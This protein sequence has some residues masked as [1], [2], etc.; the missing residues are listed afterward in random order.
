MRGFV[1]ET[2][3]WRA[4]LHG[5]GALSVLAGA[6]LAQQPAVADSNQGSEVVAGDVAPVGRWYTF[7]GSASRCGVSASRS[8]LGGQLAPAWEFGTDGLIEEEPLVW[9]EHVVI[10]TVPRSKAGEPAKERVLHALR[11]QDGKS[12]FPARKVASDV[13]LG[14]SMWG[15][16][17]AYREGRNTLRVDQIGATQFTSRLRHATKGALASPLLFGSEV[18][19]TQGG[20]LE[21]YVLGAQ[22]PAWS[23]EGA[24]VGRV[25]LH[26]DVVFAVG[27]PRL[28][29][30][31]LFGVDRFSGK[32]L[33]QESSGLH[34]AKT[35]TA[36]TDVVIAVNRAYA[37]ARCDM[38]PTIAVEQKDIESNTAIF[39]RARRDK[40]E[41]LSRGGAETS[42]VA[43]CVREMQKFFTVLEG[44]EVSWRIWDGASKRE[45]GFEVVT[46]KSHP[47]WSERRVAPL[48]MG[49]AVVVGDRAYDI[50]TLRVLWQA[51]LQPTQRA[52][53]AR[54]TL[55]VVSGGSKLV[56]LRDTETHLGIALGNDGKRGAAVL[57]D[58]RTVRGAVAVDAAAKQLTVTVGKKAETHALD[59][60]LWAEDGDR[61]IYFGDEPAV[62]R[63]LGILVEE[64]LRNGYA[65]L[66]RKAVRTNDQGRIAGLVTEAML[67]GAEEKDISAA[68]RQ[69]ESLR[70]APQRVSDAALAEVAAEQKRVDNAAADIP[71]KRAQA[72]PAAAP[73]WL[74]RTLMARVFALDPTHAGASAAVRASLPADAKPLEP[75]NAAQWF[76]YA[77]AA[78]QTELHVV[79]DGDGAYALE[80]VALAQA[81]ETWRRDLM[82]VCSKRLCVLAPRTI[83]AATARCL[84]TGELVLDALEQLFAGIGTR[85]AKPERLII[86]L[87][88]SQ[89]E[90]LDKAATELLLAS[91]KSPEI[92][93]DELA[94]EGFDPNAGAA[95]R[96]SAPADAEEMLKR[97]RGLGLQLVA[98]F[99]NREEKVTRL[100]VPWGK[101]GYAS[102]IR[103]FSHELTHHWLDLIG[104]RLEPDVKPAHFATRRGCW[105]IEGFADFIES[106]QWDVDARTFTAR[107]VPTE[108]L[109]ALAHLKRADLVPWPLMF[110][111]SKLRF[112]TILS[113]TEGPE[114]KVTGFLGTGKTSMYALVYRQGS[115]TCQYLYHADDGKHRKALLEYVVNWYSGRPSQLT[116]EVAFGMSAP[117]LGKKVVEFAK[118]VVK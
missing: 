30:P 51:D 74:R 56:A 107:N 79:A 12:L 25:S 117:E 33:A 37:L 68:Q 17:V 78:K 70:R 43:P 14:V 111:I 41:R 77:E 4:C 62:Q 45:L 38:A 40:A 89:A 86:K 39:T 71:W 82:A 16:L 11:L 103:T 13:P 87:Y 26:G 22:Q 28:I 42:I 72:L 110:S 98:G 75:F 3:R 85:P 61:P 66:A 50:E 90:F 69:I 35:N 10:V 34:S 63:A 83:P 65:G 60:V 20:R 57:R 46:S 102:A 84:S 59:F 73:A 8:I 97:K 81:R 1:R 99:F 2:L 96:E 91:R 27:Y 105:I 7:G 53:P 116:P 15:R 5:V 109:D 101:E 94:D 21:R 52:V 67:F 64:Q 55:L 47:E 76:A 29:E 23:I 9:D 118:T 92:P 108:G 31:T 32:V 36:E 54:E 115:S 80:F 95:P 100:F 93:A 44:K 6:V 112:E 19:Y 48:L 113:K 104:P 24:Y 58:G 106:F 49:D 18:Y 88:E 114:L